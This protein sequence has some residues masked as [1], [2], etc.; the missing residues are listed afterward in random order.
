MVNVSPLV[1]LLQQLQLV[2]TDY[3]VSFDFVF[4]IMI[5]NRLFRGCHLFDRHHSISHYLVA[6][7][8]VLQL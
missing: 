1:G 5:Y 8:S 7:I 6:P 2:K 4:T 3:D